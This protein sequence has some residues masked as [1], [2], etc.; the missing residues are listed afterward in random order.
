MKTHPFIKC[1]LAVSFGL[2]SGPLMADSILVFKGSIKTSALQVDTSGSDG[3]ASAGMASAAPTGAAFL[4]LNVETGSWSVVPYSARYHRWDY[5]ALFTDGD[6]RCHIVT[7]T[8]FFVTSSPRSPVTDVREPLR[9]GY[10][11]VLTHRFSDS[12]DLDRAGGAESHQV[13]TGFLQG[14]FTPRSSA[15]AYG[16]EPGTHFPTVMTSK[17]GSLTYMGFGVNFKHTC[18]DVISAGETYW[19]GRDQGSFILQRRLTQAVNDPTFPE[20]NGQFPGSVEYGVE[21]LAEILSSQG[22]FRIALP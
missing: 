17:F 14:A 19:S 20:I 8:P 16:L 2:V 9:Q 3:T 21:L 15:T 13:I 6:S 5:Y 18:T 10:D 4:V 22:Y 12:V 11:R 7:Q 1:F